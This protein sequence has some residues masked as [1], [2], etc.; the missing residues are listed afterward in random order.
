VIKLEI[1]LKFNS[2]GDIY[3]SVIYNNKYFSKDIFASKLLNI[4]YTQYI[5]LLKSHDA[6]LDKTEYYFHKKENC[7]NCIKY[8]KEKY[9]D[10]LVY[11]KLI[12]HTKESYDM[13]D[14]FI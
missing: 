2:F 14:K 9:S 3:I 13:I 7:E 4:K 6:Y 1:K 10:R 5:N 12:E 11:L 8:I